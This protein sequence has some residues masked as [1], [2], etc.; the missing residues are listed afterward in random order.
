MLGRV[1]N[2]HQQWLCRQFADAGYAVRR[3]VAVADTGDDIQAAVGEALGRSD[4]VVCTGGLGPTS[5]DLTREAIAALVGRRL[6]EDPATV[7]RLNAWY[8]ERHRTPPPEVLVQAQVPEGAAVLPNA[9][10]TAPGL[11]LEARPGT[12]A[13]AGRSA[14]LVM[15]PG[16]PRELRPMFT[17][18]V[19]PW[20]RRAFPLETE[21][22]C[23]TLRT[24]GVPESTMQHQI[25]RPL[26]A[27]V[28]AGLEV[29][30]CARPGEV[31]VRLLGRGADARRLVT[32]AE[33]VVRQAVGRHVYGEESDT[34]EAV[35]VRLLAQQGRTLTVA[36]S[37]TGGRLASRLTD[38]PGAS[39]VFLGGFIT[40]ANSL[41]EALVGVRPETLATH[42]AVSEATVREMAAGARQRTGASYALAITGVAGPSGGTPDKPVGTA[43]IGLAGAAGCEFRRVFNPFDRET[44]KHMT[45]QQALELLRQGLAPAAVG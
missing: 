24:T 13:G 29:G 6:Q 27:L 40:Y 2:T 10:G 25:A 32:A 21:F 14:W 33:V 26:G 11:L 23:R 42:G 12:A 15:L 41:K 34:L 22:V 19:L 37:C 38:V 36:E 9:H 31:D 1:L 39:A 45:T 7:A 3:Q 4:L 44:F 18:Q 43:F 30:Y 20:V 5:D 35:V 28:A 8:T 17:D 16:P